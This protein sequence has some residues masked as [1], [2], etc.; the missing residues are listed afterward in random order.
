MLS[1]RLRS[2]RIMTIVLIVLLFLQYEFGMATIMA[3]IPSRA[4]LSF[5]IAA[6]RG[7]LEQAGAVPSAHA[8]FGGLVLL[9]ALV[10]LILALRTGVRSLQVLGTLEFIFILV[11][12]G[13]GLFFVLSG[14]Q[15]D[16][17]SHTMATNFLLAFAFAFIELY[18]IRSAAN[19]A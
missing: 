7:A 6:L 17:A 11:A 18:Y 2:L 16:H 14:F 13:G 4:P 19:P 3:D 8:D 9:A 1:N 5:S 12:A 15:N 10:N